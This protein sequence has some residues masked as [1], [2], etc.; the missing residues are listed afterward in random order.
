MK[1]LAV[2]FAIVLSLAAC[3]SSTKATSKSTSTTAT[4]TTST[5]ACPNINDGIPRKTTFDSAPAMSIDTTKTYT[6]TLVTDAG[7]IV[8][9]LD[10]KA[11]PKTVNNFVF[12]A[13]NHFYDGLK[14]HRVLKGFMMQGGDPSGDGTG[15]PGYEF[16][17]ELPA[18]SSV[19][20]E[21]SLAMA[22]S[23]PD[24]N[25]SQFF[26]VFSAAA[27]ASLPPNYSYFGH[28]TTGLDVVHKIEA[29]GAT[30]DPTPPNVIHKIVC[31]NITES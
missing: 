4:S 31:V 14:F 21:G 3:G 8:I 28:V 26:I 9:S 16:A 15:G 7:S 10:P 6:A 19:Y 30:R 23:G 18:T 17:D 12:L 1:K 24:T 2:T 27:G 22:N 20:T 13:H 11:A 29:D 5:S 25:G